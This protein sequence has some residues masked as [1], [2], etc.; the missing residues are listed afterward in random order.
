MAPK[1]YILVGLGNPGMKYSGTR[2]NVGFDI[3]DKVASFS[4]RG[5]DIEKW[6]S[7]TV[8]ISLWDAVI[9]LVKPMT[10]MNLSGKAV[11]RF[12]HFYK[13]P[14]DRMIVVHDDLDMNTGRL[15][16]VKGGGAGGHNGIRSIV[17]SLGDN[18]FF[19]L[20]IG[21]GRPGNGLTPV[22]MPVEKYV[23]TGFSKEEN[24]I[25]EERVTAVVDGLQLFFQQDYLKSMNFLNSFK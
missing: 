8:K 3:A 7:H 15:K 6:D 19:R 23:L 4:G 21:I 22:E 9:H 1:N 20:K 12:A 14:L 24:R 5:I 13:I 17:Q 16:L 25:I 18:N 10:Y 11:A 2:H